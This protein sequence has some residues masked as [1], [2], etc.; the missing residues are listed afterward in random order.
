MNIKKKGIAG[1]WKRETGRD[2]LLNMSSFSTDENTY[3]CD[4]APFQLIAYWVIFHAFLSSADF[5]SKLTFRKY[6]QKVKQFGP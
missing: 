4:Q 1:C 2:A 3:I 5:F 6:H